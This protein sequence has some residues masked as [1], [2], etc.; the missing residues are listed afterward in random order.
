[1]SSPAYVKESATAAATLQV[2]VA[3]LATVATLELMTLWADTA[4][5]GAEGAVI[6]VRQAAKVIGLRRRQISQITAAEM[7]LQ[8]TLRVGKP[9]RLPDFDG[10]PFKSRTSLDQI[11]DEFVDAV[12]RYAPEALKPNPKIPVIPRKTL[13][14]EKGTPSVPFTPYSKPPSRSVDFA[15]I[16]DEALDGLID[17][18]R[19]EEAALERTTQDALKAFAKRE[20]ARERTPKKG[21]KPTKKKRK[22]QEDEAAESLEAAQ[23]SAGQIAWSASRAHAAR[24]DAKVAQRDPNVVGYIRVH[25]SF[26]G[27]KPC[28]FCAALLSRGAVYKSAA[29]AGGQINSI[30]QYHPNCRCKGEAVYKGEDPMSG[31]NPKYEANRFY[32]S[33]W[34][35][36]IK[37]KNLR[38][39]AARKTW[40]NT[41]DAYNRGHWRPGDA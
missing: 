36:Q 24:M 5:K 14:P 16:V 4:A 31:N 12:R 22:S 8:R 37:K 26:D 15:E 11:R 9:Y 34:D 39:D 33:L 41:I 38:R 17:E 2:A 7:R 13:A 23:R 29:T 25:Y 30:T 19:A 21:D 40:R 18:L 20:V 32:K 6:F 27:S 3:Y 28:A 35:S 10:R 1:M